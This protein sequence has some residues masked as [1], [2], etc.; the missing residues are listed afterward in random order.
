M[1]LSQDPFALHT[2]LGQAPGQ[3]GL[4]LQQPGLIEP[5]RLGLGLLRLRHG[6]FPAS[7]DPGRLSLQEGERDERSGGPGPQQRFD[8]GG[9]EGLE[10][11]D[12]L[13]PGV[14][15]SEPPGFVQGM[16]MQFQHGPAQGGPQFRRIEP[17]RLGPFQVRLRKLRVAQGQLGAAQGILPRRLGDGTLGPHLFCQAGHTPLQIPELGIQVVGRGQFQVPGQG[18]D[19]LGRLGEPLGVGRLGRGPQPLPHGESAEDGHGQEH[20]G[21]GRHQGLALP[22]PVEH[23]LRRGGRAG[24]DGF[25]LQDPLEVLTQG[26]GGG[27]APARVLLEA[28]EH[29]G[30]EVHGD[31]GHHAPQRHR[32]VLDDARH[33]VQPLSPEGRRPGEQR[34]QRGSQGIDIRPA[35]QQGR[36]APGLLRRHVGHRAHDPAR[37][38]EPPALCATSQSEIEHAG[39]GGAVLGPVDHQVGGLQV[40]VDQAHAVGRMDPL[41]DFHHVPQQGLERETRGGLLQGGPAEELHGDVGLAAPLAHFVDPADIGMV[42]PG[43]ELSLL[44]EA[45]EQVRIL[46]AEELQRDLPLE[47]RVR[48]PEDASHPAF[49]QQGECLEPAPAIEGLGAEHTALLV[50]SRGTGDPRRSDGAGGRKPRCGRLTERALLRVHGDRHGPVGGFGLFQ[51]RQVLFEQ[52]PLCFAQA[53]AGDQALQAGTLDLARF[54]APA[55][56]RQGQSPLVSSRHASPAPRR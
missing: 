8:A 12:G 19:A 49:A 6:L 35:I 17:Q 3:Q 54:E 7:G 9:G 30:L 2:A 14:V 11:A 16:L 31:R 38:S 45:L 1:G 15:R 4:G 26:P 21:R 33:A 44:Q 37:L 32:I 43:L 13:L 51:V 53:S 55:R 20:R 10:P 41:A 28:G 50:A 22:G 18:L 52:A 27:V 40:P 39:A 5:G 34:M 48:G 46:P 24:L 25:A 42:H 29:H 56:H 36:V 47:P 23:P